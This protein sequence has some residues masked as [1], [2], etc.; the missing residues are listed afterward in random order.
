MSTAGK[1]VYSQKTLLGNWFEHRLELQND[2]EAHNS[3]LPNNKS[4]SD[5][6][7]YEKKLKQHF[8]AS[9]LSHC[10]ENGGVKF[11]DTIMLSS[12]HTKSVLSTDASEKRYILNEECRLATA[13][14]KYT[15]PVLRNS[16]VILPYVFIY[17]FVYKKLYTC[18]F[19][20]REYI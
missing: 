1:G 20:E 3:I 19:C 5:F 6:I 12:L 11:G 13:S 4:D 7:A 15:E 17:T 2:S 18:I 14:S 8:Q 10:K 9:N 16:F